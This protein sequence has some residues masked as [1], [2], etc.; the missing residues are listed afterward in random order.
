VDK[1]LVLRREMKGIRKGR[2]EEGER[3]RGV[4]RRE[5][6]KTIRE[7]GVEGGREVERS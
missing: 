5:G 6:R 4:G 7:R 1:E 3:E 2:E